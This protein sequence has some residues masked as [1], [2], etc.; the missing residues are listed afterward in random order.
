[1]IADG[2]KQHPELVHELR[3]VRRAGLPKLRSKLASLPRLQSIA[4]ELYGQ[5]TV[6]DIEH[7]L[8]DGWRQLGTG[9][10]G[11][12]IGTL[13]GLAQGRRGG[14]PSQL[15]QAA[16]SQLGYATV[17]T[18]RKSPETEA[19]AD[20]ADQ[21]ISLRAQGRA[22]T[23]PSDERVEAIVQAVEELTALE[24]AELARRLATRIGPLPP[25]T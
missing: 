13:F 11:Q 18:F 23:A 15:R 19:M 20:L 3:I 21:L 4:N 16:A 25:R 24:L 17:E 1:V 5:A 9:R 2:T 14:A 12:A 7:L 8:T 6:A 10:H 22:R